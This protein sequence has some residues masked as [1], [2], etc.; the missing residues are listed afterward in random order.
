MPAVWQ[1]WP[2]SAACW[3]PA[4]P[5][6]RSGS[7]KTPAGTQPNAGAEGCTSGRMA[8]GTRGRPRRLA[9]GDAGDEERLAK[10]AGGNHAERV[11]R[12]M[13]FR[14]D[15]ARHAQQPQQ[16]VVPLVGVDV[17]EERARGVGDVGDVGPIA[18]EL[19]DEPRVH[20]AE[21]EL[22]ARRALTR[23]RNLV[24]QPCELGAAEV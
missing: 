14:Q 1:P 12:R 3:S 2:N 7:P 11:R 24:E 18:G 22:P 9:A 15:G 20:G 23:A 19:P 17:E 21:R 8:R 5:A 4:T 13:H 6:M 16:L 10:D